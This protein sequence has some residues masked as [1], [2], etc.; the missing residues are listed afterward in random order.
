[1]AGVA[2]PARNATGFCSPGLQPTLSAALA[3]GIDPAQA[4]ASIEATLWQ[5][6]PAIPLFQVVTTVAST[7]KGDHAT[8]N[9][10]PGPLAL[11]PF[12]TAVRWQPVSLPK[13]GS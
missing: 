4:A 6:L 5:Q 8:G 7:A 2:Q 9:I 10:A 12:S 1:M 3:G 11:G 13:P